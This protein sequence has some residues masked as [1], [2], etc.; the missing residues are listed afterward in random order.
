MCV[1][2][3]AGVLSAQTAPQQP[4]QPL[5]RSGVQVVEVDVRVFDRDGRFVHDLTK[6]DFELVEGGSAQQIQTVFLVDEG[7]ATLLPATPAPA[8]E[9]A[10]PP[11][12]AAVPGARHTWIFF[13]DLNH[14][15]PGGGF[16]RARQAVHDFIRDRF[17]QGD[18]GGVVDG[19]RMV[20]NRLTSVREELV[21]AASSVKPLNERRRLYMEMS[22]EWPPL[23]DE[24]EVWQISRNDRDALQRAVIRACSEDP[25]ACGRVDPEPQIRAKAQRVHSEL[26]R[27]SMQTLNA[28]HG[29]AAGLAKMPGPKTVVFLTDGF[30]TQEVETTLRS[31]VG[32][33]ARAGARF[34]AIDVRG[35]NRGANPEILNQRAVEDPA[36]PPPIQ[37]DWAE[38]APNSLSVDTGG[39]MIR[40]ENDIGRALERI[41][42]DA[43]RYYVLAYQPANTNFDG[44]YRAIE[45]RVRRPGV[46]VRAR[47]GYLALEPARMLI[48]RPIAAPSEGGAGNAAGGGAAAAPESTAVRAS[49][50]APTTPG[51]V[52]AGKGAP[53]G[54]ARLRPDAAGNVAALSAGN[55]TD[56]GA[57]A[58]KGWDAYQ[59]GDVEAALG[60]LSEAAAAPDARPWVLYALGLS[61]AALGKPA[62]AALSWERVRQA[63]PDFQPVYIDLADTYVQL[64]NTTSALTV[65]RDA[66][67]RWPDSD[68]VHNAIGVIHVSRGALDD[69]IASFQKAVASARAEA[70]GYLNLGR[71]Y[72]LRYTR[73]RRWVQSQR[74][75]VAPTGDRRRAVEAYE[76]CVK[77]GGPYAAQASEALSRLDWSR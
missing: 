65:L 23:L 24:Y 16:D 69:A 54:A 47:R 42:Q 45:V 22:R 32:Q 17:K 37:L 62:D 73:G 20:N 11:A 21:A 8:D 10:T 77:L 13:F 56:A 66:E 57:L 46:R 35:L 6:D 25:N 49:S 74:R 3:V 76:R 7:G 67:K 63:A 36:G 26:Q 53:S 27:S 15:T 64:S 33:A 58:G 39:M 44:K 38:D 55:T 14:L 51:A 40:N 43:G 31:V 9:P 30:I 41:A 61:Q 18:L 1:L 59:R 72:E 70:L 5:F 4:Q 60:P 68:D 19:T 52:V 12:R 75:W 34:Y 71:A 28:V 2:A 48:P 29:L 50:P